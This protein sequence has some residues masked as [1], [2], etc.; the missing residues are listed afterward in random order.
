[1]FAIE[2]PSSHQVI[3]QISHTEILIVCKGFYVSDL[4][5]RSVEND[6]MAL[7]FG[8]P[9]ALE[10]VKKSSVYEN[11]LEIDTEKA[12]ADSDQKANWSNEVHF[13]LFILR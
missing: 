7:M 3:P 5:K 12:W 9:V 4:E 2:L 10:C 8:K 1:M 13:E 11:V 6:F